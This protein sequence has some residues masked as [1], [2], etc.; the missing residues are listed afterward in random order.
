MFSPRNYRM[1]PFDTFLCCSLEVIF[2][3]GERGGGA[4][5]MDIEPGEALSPHCTAASVIF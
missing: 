3:I 4:H 1:K 2:F 5:M